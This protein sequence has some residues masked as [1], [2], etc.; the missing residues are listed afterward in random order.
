MKTDKNKKTRIVAWILIVVLLGGVVIPTILYGGVSRY[1][2]I[3]YAAPVHD[4]TV[5][6][7]GG[8]AVEE[9]SEYDKITFKIKNTSSSDQTK[10]KLKVTYAERESAI[11]TDETEEVDIK[12]GSEKDVTI[13]INALDLKGGKTYDYKIKLYV[14]GVAQTNVEFSGGVAKTT[15]EG[16]YLFNVYRK[17]TPETEKQY[18]PRIRLSAT[19][20]QNGITA[21]HV[22]KVTVKGKNLGNSVLLD[23][24][25]GIGSL[26]EGVTLSNQGTRHEVGS[27]NINAEQKAEFNLSVK[28]DVKT[29]NY[30][31]SLSAE[32]RL[33]DGATFST[34]ETV[35]IHIIGNNKEKQKGTIVIRNVSIPDKAKA[36]SDFV[37][38]FE[39]VN[40]GKGNAENVKISVEGTEGVV[41]K[42]RGI[43]VEDKI[44]SG[45][46]KKYSVTFFSNTKAEPKN[47]PI[48]ISVEPT[49]NKEGEENILSNSQY[50]GVYIYGGGEQEAKQTGV[51]NPQIMI[52]N[53]EYGGTDVKAGE[54]FVLTMTLVNTSK[55]PLTNIKASLTS[56]EGV[57]VPVD[58]SNS[59]F[60][61]SLASKEKIK[62][63]I[64]FSTKPSA[65]Q[66]T[67]GIS[68]DYSYEDMQGNALTAKDVIS[69]PVVQKTKLDVGEV[70]LSSEGIFVGQPASVSVPFYNVGKTVLSNLNITAQGDFDLEDKSGYFV[71]NMDSGKSDS[72]DFNIL[73]QMS[74][75]GKGT[76]TFT[77][78]DVSGKQQIVTK[79]FVFEAQEFV[80]PEEP[81]DVPED[82]GIGSKKKLIAGIAA[83]IIAI[84]GL[85]IFLKKRKKKKEQELEIRE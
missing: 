72:F 71:G 38:S 85:V 83:G 81:M 53:Y 5:S 46:N 8:S 49:S 14:N 51:K 73:P 33:P 29:G 4:F 67:S 79:E 55:K 12:K 34:E 59:F 9:S 15:G 18:N 2:G 35:Y 52:E 76:I 39:V 27:T 77:F 26:P 41:N 54:E 45:S 65:E 30:P 74:G 16:R 57:F 20:P 10:V 44:P 11:L 60:I 17:E 69:V 24:K 7:V 19:I 70:N 82:T 56:D 43:F 32:G 22:N 62:K 31:I 1:F 3:V 78:E 21:G 63:S 61:D 40:T 6:Q 84:F 37:L 36:G 58:S 75:E 50:A 48:K 64:R 80:V 68:I 13:S 25:L 23:M 42:T 47:Y 28:D 66:K